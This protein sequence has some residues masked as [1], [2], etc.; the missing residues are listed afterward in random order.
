M[1]LAS[2]QLN[3]YCRNKIIMCDM[4]YEN[5]PIDII[6]SAKNKIVMGLILSNIIYCS[7]NYIEL[8]LNAIL[9]YI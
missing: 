6:I 3:C 1:K 5:S 4:T 8:I 9:N 2:K 7:Q